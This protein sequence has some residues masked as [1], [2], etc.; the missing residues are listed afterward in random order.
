MSNFGEVSIVAI[1]RCCVRVLLRGLLRY[2]G[3]A[4]AFRAYPAPRRGATVAGR[5]PYRR[6]EVLPYFLGWCGRAGARPSHA[7]ATS[8]DPPVVSGRWRVLGAASRRAIASRKAVP[9]DVK[10][11]FSFPFFRNANDYT[12]F[13]LPKAS[14]ISKFQSLRMAKALAGA[15]PNHAPPRWRRSQLVV[16]FHSECH[17]G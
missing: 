10:E 16:E 12:P 8:C 11:P 14:G 4:G 1:I 17:W 6:S 5:P 15:I 7:V 13:F 3:L 9:A 2:G